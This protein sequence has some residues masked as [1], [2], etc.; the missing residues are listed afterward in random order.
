MINILV[1]SHGDLGQALIRA[2]EMIYGPIKAIA[3]A[4]LLPGEPPEAFSEKL[5]A[6]LEEMEGEETLI[7]IDLFGGTPNNVAARYVLEENVACVTGVN[8]PMVLE[9]VT[10]REDASL[11]DLAQEI[12]RAGQESVKDLGPI[13]DR[14][15]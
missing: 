7:L 8:L 10:S 13:F 3:E 1:V 15:D 12:A 6:V 9:A 14:S 4:A 5:D 2:A 11:A